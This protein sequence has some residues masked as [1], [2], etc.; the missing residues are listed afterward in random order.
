MCLTNL[1]EQ[2]QSIHPIVLGSTVELS[3][4]PKFTLDRALGNDRSLPVRTGQKVFD[5]SC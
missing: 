1:L 4:M 3:F 2:Y 5:R